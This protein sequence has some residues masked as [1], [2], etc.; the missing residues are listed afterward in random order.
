MQRVFLEAIYIKGESIKYTC[1]KHNHSELAE[2]V[3][4]SHMFRMRNSLRYLIAFSSSEHE[5]GNC[6]ITV[7]IMLINFSRYIFSLI[8]IAY[9]E[10][11]QD[12][13]AYV[14]SVSSERSE[15][16]GDSRL[17]VLLCFESKC[18]FQE[19]RHAVNLP[20]V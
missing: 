1:T 4:S 17:S 19:T 15:C 6:G 10:N 2:Y 5:K 14:S 3:S 9:R 12:T 16:C 7:I 20:I 8:W 13:S 18:P 11:R